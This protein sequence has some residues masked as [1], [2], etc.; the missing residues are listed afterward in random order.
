VP[1]RVAALAAAACLVAAPGS[2]RSTQP[3]EAVLI[4]AGDIA[5]C[6]SQGDEAT[7]RLLDGLSGTLAALGDL[8]YER[9]TDAEF[10]Q[11]YSPSWGRHKRRTRP[12]LGNHDYGTGGAGGYFRYFGAAAGPRRGFYSYE[13]GAW[14]IVVLNSNCSHA[15][16]CGV[17]SPQDSWLRADLAAHPAHCTLAYAHHP[18]FSSGLHGSDRTLRALWDALYDA[19]ADVALGGHDHHYERLRPLNPAGRPDS[20]RG[21]RQFVVGT[22]GRSLRPAFSPL[23]ASVARRH[24][25]FGVLVLRL[26]TVAYTW[27]FVPTG[28]SDFH[29]AGS[30]RCHL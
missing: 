25:D 26:R 4:A 1:I 5:S 10:R 30:A 28:A 21:I 19:G 16:G 2:A 17:G 27:E 7:A 6:H 14:H 18:R 23:K 24:T 13:L 8:A 12:A 15:G 9:G 29:D 20:R 22:G 3:P 11:C